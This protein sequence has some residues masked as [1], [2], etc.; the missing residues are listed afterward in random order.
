MPHRAGTQDDRRQI[1]ED[2]LQDHLA[3]A[4]D[5]APTPAPA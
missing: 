1:V 2:G 4:R 3:D 5:G